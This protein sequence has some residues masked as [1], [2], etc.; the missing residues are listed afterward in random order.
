MLILVKTDFS[1]DIATQCELGEFA[2]CHKLTRF[3]R[4]ISA[5]KTVCGLVNRTSMF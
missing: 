3:W 4:R 5:F 1:V 2:T